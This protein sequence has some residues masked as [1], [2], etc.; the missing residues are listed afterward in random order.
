M[1]AGLT[2]PP[3]PMTGLDEFSGFYSARGREVFKEKDEVWH[4]AG[5]FA[6]FICYSLL[7]HLWNRCANNNSLSVQ[8][9]YLPIN[10]F[11]HSFSFY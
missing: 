5:L 6:L 4:F 2:H 9:I 7:K 3:A 8:L 11:A 1:D 10:L